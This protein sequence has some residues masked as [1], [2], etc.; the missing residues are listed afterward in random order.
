MEL[1][2]NHVYVTVCLGERPLDF[3]LDTG[4]PFTFL[5]LG[6][7]RE[8]GLALKREGVIGGI[9]AVVVSAGD[10]RDR[11]DVAIAGTGLT[12]SGTRALDLSRLPAREG[13]AVGGILG[14]DFIERYVVVIDYVREELRFLDAGTFRYDGPGTSLPFRL[15]GTAPHVDA[16]VRLTDGTTLPGRMMV[17]VGSSGPIMITNWWADEHG[18]RGR[19]GP[20]VRRR[21][22]SGVG[23]PTSY[24]EGRVSAL[25]LGDLTVPAPIVRLHGDS[26]GSL[27]RRSSQVANIGT[28]VLRRF[29]VTLDYKRRRLILEPHA[30]TAEPFESDMSG[31]GLVLDAGGSA[32]LVEDVAD[33]TPASAAGVA[34]RDTIVAVDRQPVSPRLLD[35]LRK[36]LRKPD[37]R[38]ALTIRRGG[39]TKEVVVVTRRLV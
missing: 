6:V 3:L 34:P 32:L 13:H 33:G 39:E 10:L 12:A 27:S 24:D 20:T 4:S 18:L 31:L 35:D 5:D 9:G 11:V 8:S 29:T 19:V 16:L 37:Q 17:D 30:G 21:G 22:G 15:I 38:V 2:N 26:S 14:R 36:R 23:G 7:A 25:V 1:T 28:E